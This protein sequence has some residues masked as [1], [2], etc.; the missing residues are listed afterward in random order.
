[1]K[2]FP[3]FQ[4]GLECVRDLIKKNNFWNT[5]SIWMGKQTLILNVYMA[6]KALCVSVHMDVCLWLFCINF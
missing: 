1:M 4:N 6:T 5:G 3:E 2:D